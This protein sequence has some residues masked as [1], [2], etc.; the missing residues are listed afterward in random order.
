L[1]LSQIVASFASFERLFTFLLHISSWHLSDV[2]KFES[3]GADEN[4]IHFLSALSI[5]TWLSTD[6]TRGVSRE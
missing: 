2:P 5:E 3:Q 4:D 6:A 1:G